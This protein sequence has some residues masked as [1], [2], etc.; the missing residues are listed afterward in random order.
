VS[1]LPQRF[2]VERL[3]PG[4][5][6]VAV[7]VP[8]GANPA[9][10]EPGFAQRQAVADARLYVAVGHPA[11]LF[12]GTWLAPLLAERS[13][14][15]VAS[16][17][18]ESAAA[19][20]D[21]HVWVSPGGARPMARSIAAGLARILPDERG[22]IDANLARLL[23]DI[24]ALDAEVRDILAPV[25]GDRFVVLH[26]AWGSFAREYGLVQ[27]SIDREAKEPDARELALLIE[28]SRAAGVRVIFVQPQFNPTPAQLVAAE[29]G[30]R[31]ET[32]DPFAPDWDR[33][34]LRSAR[35]I[36]EAAVP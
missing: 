24:D 22:A 8:P 34:L 6:D 32:L 25:R 18:P 35:A 1:V 23:A 10:F 7:M 19:G 14:L 26:P 9:S 11:F 33:N 28:S 36:A 20:E 21:P 15:P 5:V 31:I 30:A 4:L 17:A 3:A 13:D 29:I 27:V 16:A 12:E 2:F